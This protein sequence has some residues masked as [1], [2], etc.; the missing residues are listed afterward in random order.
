MILGI[1]L[2]A[3]ETCGISGGFTG[4]AQSRTARKYCMEVQQP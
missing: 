1:D 3:Q 2:V 4:R